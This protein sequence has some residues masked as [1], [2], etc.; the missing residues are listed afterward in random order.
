[1]N[2]IN[3]IGL[4]R[5]GH[6]RCS[7]KEDFPVKLTTFLRISIFKNICERLVL[8]VSPQNIIANSTGKS[9]LDNTLKEFKGSI[10]LSMAILFNK[11]H[12]YNL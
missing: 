6:R 4:F 1:M 5:S 2:H 9:G 7:V 11:M 12:S 10:F 3:L 8:F